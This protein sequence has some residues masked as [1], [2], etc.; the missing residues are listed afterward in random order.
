MSWQIL[1]AIS[2]IA[3]GI[4]VLLQRVLLREDESDPVAYTIVVEFL[5]AITV[6]VFALFVG[7]KIPNNFLSL[8]PN[9]ALM[10]AVYAVG[11][12]FMFKS[13]KRIEASEFTILFA[14][15]TFWTIIGAIIFLGESFLTTQALGAIL[16]FTSVV[17]VSWSKKLFSIQG[18]EIQGL[19]AGAL[20]GLGFIND[21]YILQ[22]FDS[23]TYLILAFI[24]PAIALTIAF[25]KSTKKMKPLLRRGNFAKMAILSV[26]YAIS[27]ITFFAAYALGRNAAQLS[28]LDQLATIVTVVLAIIFLKEKAHL[29]RKIAGAILSFLGVVLL[30]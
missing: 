27:G 4:S 21:A 20:F 23:T 25:P 26:L 17:L 6:T 13:L 8:L 9:I 19:L 28:A 7:F 22:S 24:L 14:T 2:I 12:T 30:K 5:G 11:S 10:T 15:R 29:V 18:G 16:I 3:Y 1:L